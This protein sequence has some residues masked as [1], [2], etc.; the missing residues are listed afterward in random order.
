MCIQH[1]EPESLS[2]EI[3]VPP[4]LLYATRESSEQFRYKLGWVSEHHSTET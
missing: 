3:S 1:M 4:K 2:N